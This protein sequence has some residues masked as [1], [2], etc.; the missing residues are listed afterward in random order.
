MPWSRGQSLAW[1]FTCPDTL[2]ASH[3]NVAVTGPGQVAYHAKQ[4][5]IDKY[6]ALSK[7][8]QF[9]LIDIETLGPVDEEATRFLQELGRRIDWLIDWL[10]YG[11]S[12]QKGY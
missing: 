2:T 11:T 3:L 6:A 10:L 1:D 4:L 9:I 5:K 12:A 7:E 8:F